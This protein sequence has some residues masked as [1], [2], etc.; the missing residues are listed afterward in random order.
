M[1][2]PKKYGANSSYRMLHSW[3]EKNL[4]KPKQC[5]LCGT[6]SRKTYHWANISGKYKKELSDWRRLCV[7]CHHREKNLG[8]C[9][10]KHKLTPINTYKRKNSNSIECRICRT[11]I[12]KVWDALNHNS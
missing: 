12:K 8:Y 10:R 5:V 7:T 9:I 11:M 3:V 2:K 4:G 6:T 1:D